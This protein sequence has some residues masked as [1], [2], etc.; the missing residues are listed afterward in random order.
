MFDCPARTKTLQTSAADLSADASALA[1]PGTCCGVTAKSDA[2]QSAPSEVDMA[3]MIGAT[4][5]DVRADPDCGAG[6]APASSGDNE[7][8]ARSSAG[9][10]RSSTHA[11]AVRDL[12]T[13][14]PARRVERKR[15]TAFG[16]T[17]CPY[18]D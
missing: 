8:R 2:S 1:D 18:P 9:R 14:V 4:P 3:Q 10:G 11:P 15:F 16:R 7:A 17:D 13:R 12:A 5:T 6:A